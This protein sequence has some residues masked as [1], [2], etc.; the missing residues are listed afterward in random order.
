[1][2]K[3][4]LLL[5]SLLLIFYSVAF[6]QDGTRAIDYNT[7]STGR[8]GVSI[9][10]FD[11]P[12][13]MLTNPAGMSFIRKP[14]LNANAIFM[15][16]PTHFKNYVKDANG[17]TT[18]TILNDADGEKMLYVMP[19]LSYVHNFK[20][21]KFTLGAGVFTTG[22]MGTEGKFKHQ[23]FVDPAFSTNYREQVYR[24]RFAI[25]E[26]AVSCSYL[27]TPKFSV[28]ITGEFVYSTLELSQPFSLPPSFLKGNL[29]TSMGMTTYAKYFSD[30]RPVG[31]GYKE[32]TASAEMTNLKSYTFGGKIGF[33]YKCS[34]KFSVGASYTMSVPLNYKNGSAKMDMSSQFS[35]ASGVAA[36]NLV[37][38]YHISLD[39]AA[40][41]VAALFAANGINPYAGF[42]A[43]YDVNN[44][45]KTP[46]S[47]GFGFMYSPVPKLR[48][49]FD[50]EWLNWS[51]A[52]EKM[53]LT[54]TNGTNSN[55]NKM[56]VN[57]ASGSDALVVEFP[58]KWKDA[59]ILKF[60]GEYDVS[61]VL[62]LRAGYSYS[63]NP[64]PE[65]TII[66]IMPAIL[67]HH[68]MAGCSYDLVKQLTLSMA[69]EYGL[70][71]TVTGSNPHLVATEY[72]NSE[73]SLQNLLG[74]ISLTYN[75]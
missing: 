46:Q 53:T 8:G 59:I 68:V 51:K 36:Q 33:A 25:I 64:I 41:L 16:P 20:D 37:N 49:G 7:R 10:F 3:K 5:F 72:N 66:P 22:G 1:M 58:M 75:F 70:K 55:I 43:N 23:L 67:E 62:T 73:S 47:A 48:L 14:V 28:G 57:G 44:E 71:N 65:E 40:K 17:N 29:M 15:V 61:N 38:V 4:S 32:L 74:H 69:L 35:E 9:G 30:P 27:I 52:F 11:N 21:S 2:I 63:K 39:S 54:L 42:V 19:S 34:D 13:T 12:S 24:S 56:L 50:F 60:G 18:S 26:S 31:L 45:F 6:S